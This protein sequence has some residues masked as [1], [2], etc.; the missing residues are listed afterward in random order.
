MIGETDA[1][2][3]MT[4]PTEPETGATGAAAPPVSKTWAE[5]G[6]QN[7]AASKPSAHGRSLANP[8][9]GLEAPPAS[10]GDRETTRP[11]VGL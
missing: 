9:A 8:P 4:A 10:V 11:A 2:A 6:V 1:P 5:T 3:P 7:N